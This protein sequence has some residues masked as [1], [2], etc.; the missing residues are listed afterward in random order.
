MAPLTIALGPGFCA[1]KDATYVI[2]TMRGHDLARIISDGYA[3]PNT[4]VPGLVG[5][6]DVL[7]VIHAE[8]E[9]TI[10]NISKISDVVNRGQVIAKILTEEG[11]T[12]EVKASLN[13]VLRGL[14][15]SGYNVKKGLKIADIDP[16]AEEK[17]NC[18]T[19]SDKARALGGSVLQAI[20]MYK[21]SLCDSER[22]H[23]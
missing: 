20:G 19:I 2:E 3:I 7:R 22:A 23:N 15:K 11:E 16:R 4:G 8:C 10:N 14:I 9:G 6:Q 12:V 18:F 21:K 13:G 5:G 17:E 1:G